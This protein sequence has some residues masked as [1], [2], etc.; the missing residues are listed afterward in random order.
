[1]EV[2]E[3]AHR[4]DAGEGH[5]GVRGSRQ[6]VQ[7]IG[8]E[9]GGDVVHG[10]PPTPEVLRG[11]MGAGPQ[12]TMEHVTV[13]IDEP[14]ERDPREGRGVGR[15]HDDAVGHRG[16]HPVGDVEHDAGH[17][18]LAAEPRQLAPES[19]HEPILATNSPMRA[20][21]ASLWNASYISQVVNVAGSIRSTIMRPSR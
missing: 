4:R 5:L 16:D 6:G 10:V 1:M 2:V 7:R 12:R 11:G 19:S 18:T 14:G 17:R 13:G 15:R 21:N 9:G 8:V 20:T 3:L